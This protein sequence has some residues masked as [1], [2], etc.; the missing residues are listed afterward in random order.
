MQF[1]DYQKY[2]KTSLG[3][4]IA[5]QQLSSLQSGVTANPQNIL[6]GVTGLRYISRKERATQKL[7]NSQIYDHEPH[8]EITGATMYIPERSPNQQDFVFPEE[9]AQNQQVEQPFV[10]GFNPRDTSNDEEQ[11]M[12]L[13]VK[14]ERSSKFYGFDNTSRAPLDTNSD[15]REQFSINKTQLLSQTSRIAN[16]REFEE[17]NYV[18]MNLTNYDAHRVNE[19]PRENSFKDFV[20]HRDLPKDLSESMIE[21]LNDK[22]HEAYEEANREYVV[23]QFANRYHSVSGA[24]VLF[25][26][27]Y[28][29]SDIMQESAII[30]SLLS[31][32]ARALGELQRKGMSPDRVPRS[33]TTNPLDTENSEFGGSPTRSKGRVSVNKSSAKKKNV[34]NNRLFEQ[35]NKEYYLKRDVEVEKLQKASKNATGSVN[36]PR[37]TTYNYDSPVKGGAK[38]K[39]NFVK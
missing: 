18:K 23:P 29:E 11:P 35:F 37:S 24:K 22:Y 38:P 15:L 3:P 8:H 16:D 2:R 20:G 4:N 39:S 10:N 34:L 27:P 17:K 7:K 9:R 19:V 33:T 26:V 31:P 12:R 36:S 30:S 13:S 14:M 1:F 21:R 25:D 32:Q 5:H 28:V 6:D